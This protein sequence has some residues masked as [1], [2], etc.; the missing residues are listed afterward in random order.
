MSPSTD[1]GQRTLGSFSGE[2][3]VAPTATAAFHGDA[4]FTGMLF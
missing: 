3:L 2:E 4:V 1:Q